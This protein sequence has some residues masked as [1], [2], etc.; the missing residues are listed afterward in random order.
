[1]WDKTGQ[2]LGAGET[3]KW[4]QIGLLKTLTIL[5]CIQILCLIISNWKEK[6]DKMHLGQRGEATCSTGMT[7]VSFFPMWFVAS[8]FNLCLPCTLTSSMLERGSWERRQMLQQ[9]SENYNHRTEIPPEK[10]GVPWISL[11]PHF[12]LWWRG[13]EEDGITKCFKGVADM[14]YRDEKGYNLTS[15]KSLYPTQHFCLVKCS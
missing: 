1:M 2:Y 3:G 13:K 14:D 6:N 12:Q 5:P 4:W 7:T 9:T 10:A 8:L 15:M 11:P